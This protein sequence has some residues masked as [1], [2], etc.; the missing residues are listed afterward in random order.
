M[1]IGTGIDIIEVARIEKAIERWGDNFLKHVFTDDEIAY[2][3]NNKNPAQHF[4]ARFAAKEA[5]FKA[6]G[7]DPD[8]HWKDIKVVN[9]SYGKPCC[10]FKDNHFKYKISISLS[11]TKNYAVANA[12]I[13][14]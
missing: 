12:I 10:I 5:V 1:I 4:A 11:H 6:I 13:S 14:S 3:Q 9:D 2:A 7:N 8:I